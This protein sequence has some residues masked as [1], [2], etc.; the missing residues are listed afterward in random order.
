[1]V[2]IVSRSTDT[3]SRLPASEMWARGSLEASGRGMSE[4][5]GSVTSSAL[6]SSD[7]DD[8]ADRLRRRY[9]PPRVPR[10][11]VITLVA[12]GVAVAL[13]WLI[14]AASSFATPPVSAQVAA[15]T[16]VSDTAIDV[17]LTVDR[18]DPSRP[19]TCRILAQSSDFQP[20]AEQ[21]IAIEPSSAR[22]VD[23]HVTLTTLR[24]ATTAVAKGCTLS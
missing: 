19:A 2:V 4:H 15:Y 12:V 5:N 23:T 22:L 7:A 18:R 6:P 10:R 16:V 11:V 9:P 17:T 8:V 14:W 13:A 24:R 21:Q 3:L 1:M 20:V